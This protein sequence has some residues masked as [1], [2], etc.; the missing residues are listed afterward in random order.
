MD[1]LVVQWKNNGLLNRRSYVR[2]VA[3]VQDTLWAGLVA[4]P[5]F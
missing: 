5:D 2:V 4:A 3:G 1:A